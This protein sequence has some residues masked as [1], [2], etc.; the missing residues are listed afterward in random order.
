MWGRA[1]LGLRTLDSSK[2]LHQEF[3]GRRVATGLG[4]LWEGPGLPDSSLTFF[5]QAALENTPSGSA[6]TARPPAL[7]R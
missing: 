3:L 5:G 6:L 4:V 2:T 1:K 7:G